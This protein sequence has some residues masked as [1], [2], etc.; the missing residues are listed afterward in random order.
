MRTQSS[1]CSTAAGST[2]LT[3]SCTTSRALCTARAQLYSDLEDA[4]C[5]QHE[6][7]SPPLSK[8]AVQ[9]R[10]WLAGSI[11]GVQRS[12]MLRAGMSDDDIAAPKDA[13]ADELRS[14]VQRVRVHRHD[15][16]AAVAVC[17]CLRPE[18][19]ADPEDD[20]GCASDA[21]EGGSHGFREPRPTHFH[22]LACVR[23]RVR[24]AATTPPCAHTRHVPRPRSA[25]LVRQRLM[26]D[27]GV[28]C[29]GTF[30]RNLSPK[31]RMKLT[32]MLA[33]HFRDCIA[34]GDW[35]FYVKRKLRVL[36]G[37]RRLRELDTHAHGCPG[38]FMLQRMRVKT[39]SPTRVLQVG[40]PAAPGPSLS[41]RC[42]TPA[43]ARCS[44]APRA[45]ARP[46]AKLA[47]P[48]RR[49]GPPSLPMPP[50]LQ[51]RDRGDHRTMRVRQLAET[52]EPPS[53]CQWAR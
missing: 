50:R 46:A 1:D 41:L 9:R 45:T 12:A 10:K 23:V 42:P 30:F 34:R 13:S 39:G 18:D 49:R 44:A 40:A 53:P 27:G 19:F 22:A 3:R 16:A 7:G 48:S 11:Q 20:I 5:A 51:P 52:P 15:W 17:K 14:F 26:Q 32:D 31:L 6:V 36:H 38:L 47:G 8:T 25:V 21:H 28:P 37:A 35:S 4:I 24:A 2:G 33:E 43:P 29:P